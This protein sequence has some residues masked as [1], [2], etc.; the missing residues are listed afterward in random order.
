MHPLGE[1]RGNLKQDNLMK[2]LS[3]WLIATA[4]SI[5]LSLLILMIVSGGAG[6]NSAGV[7]FACRG[8]LC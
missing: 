3:K 2:T 5:F 6:T 8:V 1:D 4:V 7:I